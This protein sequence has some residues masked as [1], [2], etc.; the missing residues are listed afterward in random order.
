MQM[1][2]F[3]GARSAVE[4]LCHKFELV[5]SSLADSAAHSAQPHAYGTKL[6]PEQLRFSTLVSTLLF[7]TCATL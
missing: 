3:L 2:D 5:A 7:R 6:T 4:V 1:A